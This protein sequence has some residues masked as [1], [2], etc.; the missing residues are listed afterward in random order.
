MAR[1]HNARNATHS[2]PQQIG[3]SILFVL[4]ALVIATFLG[5]PRHRLQAL[6]SFAESS[7][8][9]GTP[10]VGQTNIVAGIRLMPSVE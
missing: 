2:T 10:T 4:A 9:P 1:S 3:W 6:I 8:Q 5:P 7:I